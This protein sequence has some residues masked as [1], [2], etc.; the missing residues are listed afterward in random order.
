MHFQGRFLYAIL[1]KDV[2]EK[3]GGFGDAGLS[4]VLGHILVKKKLGVYI[5]GG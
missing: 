1:L 3:C 5:V 2:Y 4:Y